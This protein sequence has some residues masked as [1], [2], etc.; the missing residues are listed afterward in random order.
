MALWQG[1]DAADALAPGRTPR[2]RTSTALPRTRCSSSPA[3]ADG[4]LGYFSAASDG[5]DDDF[6]EQSLNGSFHGGALAPVVGAGGL[7][8]LPHGHVLTAD[9]SQSPAIDRGAPAD[10]FA[11]EPAPN[12]SYINLGAYGNTAQA[13]LSPA[14]YVL[15]TRPDGGETWPQGHTFDIAWR[16][17]NTASSVTIELLRQDTPEAAPT[18]VLVDRLPMRR[19]TASTPGPFPRPY[20]PGS[21]YLIRVTRNDDPSQSDTSNSPFTD[22]PAD[23]RLL[24]QRRHGERRGGDWTT[25]PGDNAN[26]GLTPATPKASIGGVLAAYHLNPGD[27]IRV[28]DGT[29]NLG[30]NLVLDATVSGITI[31]GYNDPAYPAR[32]GAARPRQ[33]EFQFHQRGLRGPQCGQRDPR[34]P[35]DHRRRLRHFRRHRRQ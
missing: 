26:D 19:T 21:N 35:L 20:A 33:R 1:V 24:R 11:N 14:A 34:S 23:Q 4:H 16:S 3:G 10:S 27:V 5:R 32:H 13:S 22:R 25:A 6:H 28:D 8:R 18:V 7:A 2:S 31:E 17:Q 9:P 15:V 30:V 12:G 29:Y